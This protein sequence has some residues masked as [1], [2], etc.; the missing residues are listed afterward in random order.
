MSFTINSLTQS[1][2]TMFMDNNNNIIIIIV[3]NMQ[4]IDV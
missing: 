3:E 1:T 4:Y 2:I